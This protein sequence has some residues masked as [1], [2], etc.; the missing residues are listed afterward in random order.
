MAT[1][2]MADKAK[3]K[4]DTLIDE[5]EVATSA[6]AGDVQAEL[7]NLRRDIAALTQTVASFG[8]GK[9]K[10][11]SVRAS[12]LGT[13]AADVSAQYVESARNSLRSA[14]QDLEAQIRAKPL[15]AVAIAAGV[16]FLAAL[17]SRR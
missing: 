15:Q 17:L 10:E 4:A 8:T 12:Q 1:V 7:E 6:S 13:E 11:A 5:A 3:A 14:E 16:G 2:S 9:L